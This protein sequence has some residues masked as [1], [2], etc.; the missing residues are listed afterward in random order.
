MM[1]TTLLV[2][3]EAPSQV[4]NASYADCEMKLSGPYTDVQFSSAWTLLQEN[5]GL[6][7][8][9]RLREENA[10]LEEKIA[11]NRWLNDNL[12][13][14]T[15]NFMAQPLYSPKTSTWN[16][17]D[18]GSA[19]SN[20]SI[21]PQ[22]CESY[23]GKCSVCRCPNFEMDTSRYCTTKFYKDPP[24]RMCKTCGHQDYDH[25]QPS[26]QVW[27][28]AGSILD[29]S[30]AESENSLQLQLIRNWGLGGPV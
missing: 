22:P 5:M 15:L 21:A 17:Q 13:C 9:A 26:T 12:S 10:R 20:S 24:P 25:A 16:F 8:I 1:E 7:E 14:G 27:A 18:G 30:R 23:S 4:Y 3:T 29:I 28:D 2:K 11:Q 6:Q 19:T